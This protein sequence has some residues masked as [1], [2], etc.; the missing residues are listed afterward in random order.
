MRLGSAV[1]L[2]IVAA[3]SGLNCGSRGVQ[4]A[5]DVDDRNPGFMIAF[6]EASFLGTELEV[7]LNPIGSY[8]G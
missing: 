6:D 8:G 7:L 2:H 1:E 5:C 3:K 4:N